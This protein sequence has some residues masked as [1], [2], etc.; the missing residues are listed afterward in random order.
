MPALGTDEWIEAFAAAAA[1]VPSSSVQPLVVQ[2]ELTDTGEAWHVVLDEQGARVERGHHP[3]PDVTFSQDRLT[4]LA[5]NRG[6]LAA[7]LAFVDGRLRVRGDV[8]RL[9]AA[10]ELLASIGPVRTS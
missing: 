4:A 6:E 10:A 9:A 5:I 3:A 8:G 2:Q 1:A 7:Q